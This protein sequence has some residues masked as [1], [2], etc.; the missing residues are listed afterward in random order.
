[1]TTEI[2][3]VIKEVVPRTYNVTSLRFDNGAGVTFRP[4]QFLSLSFDGTKEL[5]R[6]L[7]ISNSPTEKGY[8]EVTKKIT[9]SEFS[10]RYASAKPGDRVK[11]KIPYGNFIFD[12]QYPKI[13]FL[14][15][16]IGITPIRSMAKYIC[17]AG[18]NTD[19][20]LL[21]GNHSLKDIAFRDDFT[22][23]S[24]GAK[25]CRVVHILCTTDGGWTGKVGHIDKELILSEIPDYAERKFFIC[26]PKCMVLDMKDILTKELSMPENSVLAENFTGY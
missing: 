15:G 17:D 5:T 2:S 20:V 21:Y 6:Y 14:S 26:G 11:I 9:T 8:V 23:M 19:A 10:K 7:S 16:G 25:C 12:G 1:M 13:A 24:R 3:T 4:G 18:I 22:V